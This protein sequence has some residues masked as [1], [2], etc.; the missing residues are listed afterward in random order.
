[1]STRHPRSG[2]GA[3]S[4]TASPGSGGALPPPGAATARRSGRSAVG[5]RGEG[6]Q[7]QPPVPSPRPPC[8]P[9]RRLPVR[10]PR[11]ASSAAA[12][13]AAAFLERRGSTSGNGPGA[14]PQAS[15][16][17]VRTRPGQTDRAHRR[18]VRYGP[19]RDLVRASAGWPDHQVSPYAAARP[20]VQLTG[21]RAPAGPRAT[22]RIG[23]NPCEHAVHEWST[24]QEAR[25]RDGLDAGRDRRSNAVAAPSS[26]RC[27]P[28]RAADL[29]SA[30]A[31]GFGRGRPMPAGRPAYRRWRRWWPTP[32]SCGASPANATTAP[33]RRLSSRSGPN[34][35]PARWARDSPDVGPHRLVPLRFA[36]TRPLGRPS[37]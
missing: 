27:R 11:L 22:P 37:H 18:R 3:E 17:R 15:V 32:R 29:T 28:G 30:S 25:R 13:A 35:T 14:R 4:G 16:L 20:W 24:R 36:T 1:M 23:G 9:T 8:H 19:E 7:N 33:P 12:D 5:G 31:A 21:G 2:A 34:R 10:I 6:R 26:C